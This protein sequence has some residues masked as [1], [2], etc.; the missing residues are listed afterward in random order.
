MVR[1]S[2]HVAAISP[3]VLMCWPFVESLISVPISVV[4]KVSGARV[5]CVVVISG[6][7]VL[8]VVVIP[9]VR[10]P[11]VVVISGAS[12]PNGVVFPGARICAARSLRW[13]VLAHRGWLE[14]KFRAQPGW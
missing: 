4:V 9:G 3:I 5:P 2:L 11:N 10:V 13:L 7:S 12:V 1:I 8:N 6:A 14:F